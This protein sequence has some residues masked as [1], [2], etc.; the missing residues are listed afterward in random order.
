MRTNYALVDTMC[1]PVAP[2]R[3]ADYDPA[4][5]CTVS[6]GTATRYFGLPEDISREVTDA[7]FRI[8]DTTMEQDE[9][10]GT[11]IV[12]ARKPEPG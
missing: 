11:M 8:L 2:G 9:G 12:Q 1:G 10:H 5:R 7:G 4:S 6:K 3:F